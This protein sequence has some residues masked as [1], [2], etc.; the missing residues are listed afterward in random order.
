MTQKRTG[1]FS[2]SQ[3][4]TWSCF[5]TQADSAKMEGKKVNLLVLVVLLVVGII[6]FLFY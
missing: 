5:S 2:S 4:T 1:L 3:P 6:S